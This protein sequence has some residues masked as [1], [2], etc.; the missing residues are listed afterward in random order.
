MTFQPPYTLEPPLDENVSFSENYSQFLEQITRRERDIARK[1]NDKE[2]GFYPQELEILNSQKFFI[3]G[4]PQNYRYVFRKVFPFG[5]IVAG[6]A[7]N[8]AHGIANFVELT[9]LYGTCITAIVDYRP[10]PFNS[11]VAANQGIQVLLAGANITITNG[12]AAPNITSGII[13]AEYLKQ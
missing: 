4:D 6:A 10:I 2:R 12:A 13:I 7:L 8:I 9:A 5:A 11:V 1:V 3:N